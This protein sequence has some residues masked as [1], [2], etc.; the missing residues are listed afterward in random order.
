M[1]YDKVKSAI[2]KD[3]NPQIW[4]KKM[5]NLYKDSI[6]AEE[7]GL[8]KANKEVREAQ[9]ELQIVT[10]KYVKKLHSITNEINSLHQQIFSSK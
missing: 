9:D 8:I 4:H 1:A 5:L 10:D 2:Q 7:S 3:K 6:D